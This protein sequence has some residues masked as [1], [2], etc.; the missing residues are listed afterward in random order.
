MP[1]RMS[2]IMKTIEKDIQDFAK[3]SEAIANQTNLLALNATIEA[4]RAGD[5]GKGFGVVA[6]E[7]KVLARQAAGNADDMRSVVMKRVRQGL[8]TSA[9]LVRE[10]DQGTRL[11]DMA[12]TLVQLIVRN[13]YE[14][15]ADVRWW[16]TD[17]AFWRVLEASGPDAAARARDRLGVINRYYTVY[18]DL[19]LLNAEGDVVATAQGDGYPQ[20]ERQNFAACRWFR[21]A[22]ATKSGDD[23]VVEE[24]YD[25][26]THGGKSVATYAAAVR[27]GGD[28]RGEVLG[29]LGVFFDWG[30]QSD[31]IVCKEPNLTEEEWSRTRVMLLDAGNRVIASSDGRGIYETYHLNRQGAEKGVVRFDDERI[32]AFARTIG[33]EAY[34]GLGWTGVIEQR[35]QSD[36][37]LM[38]QVAEG[39]TKH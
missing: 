15:T 7:V 16:A 37:E 27:R 5:A 24:I 32:A 19:V 35:R 14:R 36:E 22:M 34:D 25:D 23:Y 28:P 12:Q 21:S 38:R 1:R 3:K 29:V 11:I 10:L 33:Y 31:S 9:L 17:E 6:S 39:L 20:V 30:P 13:L 18:L 8:D 26:P 4:A 2:L